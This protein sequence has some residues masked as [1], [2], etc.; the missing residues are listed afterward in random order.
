[1]STS[2]TLN[3]LEFPKMRVIVNFSQFQAATCVS[4]V[5]CAEMGGYKP[6]Q[7]AYVKF[8]ALNVDF[9]SL[10]PDPVGSRRSGHAGVKLGYPSKNGY[11]FAVGLSSVKMIAD[12]QTCYLS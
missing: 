10:R 5:N 1:M 2:M 8:S 12:R 7:P 9:S 11:L 6:R 3:D 4:R